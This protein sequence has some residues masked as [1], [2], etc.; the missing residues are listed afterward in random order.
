M[1]S[2]YRLTVKAKD[3][4]SPSKS[5]SADVTVTI[6]DVNDNRPTFAKNPFRFQAREDAAVQTS[7]GKLTAIDRD[8]GSNAEL[9][10]E[11]VGNGA[12][13]SILANGDVKIAKK[14][15]YEA[16]KSYTY[17]VKV[18]DKGSPIMSSYGKLNIQ[19]RVNISCF[20]TIRTS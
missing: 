5:A 16:T 18:I 10:Y 19:V 1:V 12:V 17:D 15:D 2:S 11:I 13:V 14:L 20:K 7:I 4:G 6:T 9:Q 3:N 8:S